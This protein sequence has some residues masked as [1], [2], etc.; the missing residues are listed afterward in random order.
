MAYGDRDFRHGLRNIINS[1]SL[2]LEAY[3]VSNDQERV[4]WMEMIDMT[5]DEA[6]E[7]ID[8]NPPPP[9]QPPAAE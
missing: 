5:A 4:Q 7:I 3:A 8:K 9:D 6:I 1:L 2:A